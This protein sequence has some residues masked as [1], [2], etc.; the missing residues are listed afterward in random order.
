MRT[1]V[2]TRLQASI[3]LSFASPAAVSARLGA[4]E[5]P[6][7]IT[8]WLGRLHTLIGVPFPYLVPDEGMLPPESIR[9]FRLDTAWVEALIDGAFSIGRNLTSATDTASTAPATLKPS[10]VLDQ[11]LHPKVTAESR[12]AAPLRRRRAATMQAGPLAVV[13]GPTVPQPWFGFIL[14]SSVVADYPG[15]GVNIYPKGHTPD[16]KG[17]Q[18]ILLPVRRLDLLGEKSDTLFC[19][20]EGEPYH[21]D[22]HEAPEVLHYGIDT[23][24]PGATPTAT[25]IL[26][27]FTVSAGKVTWTGNTDTV[28][29]G[30]AFRSAQPRV[31]KMPALA[32]KVAASNGIMS[33]NSAEMGFEMTE[34]VGKVTFVNRS[35]T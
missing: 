25:K 19:L 29:I 20:V 31:V 1:T 11:V 14:R 18:I 2:R 32:A 17:A 3:A 12:V 16:D 6:A 27:T 35:A 9:F 5:V 15:L 34:G 7:D 24:V 21:I 23:Y 26:R 28:Q 13:G 4:T 33:V 8:A 30:D 22:I 10:L